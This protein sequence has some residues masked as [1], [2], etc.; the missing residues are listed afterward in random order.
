MTTPNLFN[1]ATSEF[2]QD[3]FIC[4][5]S[6]LAKIEN[7]KED[8]LLHN[9]AI[10]FIQKLIG[11]DLEITNVEICR[12][13]Y[14]I[15]VLLLIN[16]KHAI[17]VEDKKG[18]KEHSNQLNRYKKT[19]TKKLP[20]YEVIGIYY[21]MEEQGD[22]SGVEQAEYKKITRADMLELLEK[23]K[24]GK[25]TIIQNYTQRLF[26]IENWVNSYKNLKVDDWGWHSWIGFYTYLQ[27]ELNDGNWHYVP[28]HS[29][30]FLGFWWHFKEIEESILFYVQLEQE[31]T[32][33]FKLIFNKNFDT[34]IKRQ[35]RDK[36]REILFLK[37]NN[38]VISKAGRSGG[39]SMSIAK[40]D[41]FI[42][43]KED[44]TASIEKTFENIKKIEKLFDE[45]VE[46]F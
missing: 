10:E 39:Y 37:Q 35:L 4:Y 5:L 27:K 7:K 3:A 11:E 6:E 19:V 46:N 23:Y 26:M 16:E 45:V 31:N 18:T 28:N 9:I 25:N 33:Y 8:N 1:Y 44:G 36:L 30:G 41:N 12:Q 40:I 38:F 34:N 32:I 15:D 22:Y 29:G 24:E 14:N 42:I 2:S 17:I 20:N 13:W 43:E 21:K